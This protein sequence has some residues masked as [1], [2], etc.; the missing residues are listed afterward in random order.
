MSAQAFHHGHDE[1]DP[2]D[3]PGV[4]VMLAL[5]VHLGLI[6]LI[7][8]SSWLKWNTDSSAAAAGAQTVEASLVMSAADIRAAEKTLRNAPPVPRP[9]PIDEPAQ[10][11]APPPQPLPEPNPQTAQAPQ[12]KVAQERVPDPDTKEQDEA[13]K[14]AISQEKAQQE[15]EAKHRQEQIDLTEQIRKQDE[16]QQKQRLA[17]QQLQDQQK[18]QAQAAADADKQKKLDEI[19]KQ[20]EALEKQVALAQQKQQQIADAQKRVAVAAN[21]AQSGAQ[22]SSPAGSNGNDD[23]LRAK[24]AAAIQAA[25]LRQWVRPDTVAVGTKCSLV[26]RQ[27]PGGEV[28]DVQVDT[29]N[30][31]MSAEGQESV[32]RAVLKARPLP[33]HGF[34]SVF[35]RSITFNFQ[36]QNR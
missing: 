13:S 9:K 10:D 28:M 12:Q 22:D 2:R 32:K 3:R 33:Y 36:A 23:G 1:R 16:A 4:A 8:L 29:G 21:A 5:G 7:V 15:Q 6:A 31:A 14:L 27:L 20:R 18:Q 34:E 17:Q 30:C 24:Y 25:V 35:A 26:I 11:T 19:R